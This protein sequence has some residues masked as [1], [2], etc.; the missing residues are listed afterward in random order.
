[1]D[2]KTK[3]MCYDANAAIMHHQRTSKADDLSTLKREL[4]LY[5]KQQEALDG[6]F[7]KELRP[8]EKKILSD[9]YK[10]QIKTR[11]GKIKQIYRTNRALEFEVVDPKRV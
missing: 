2:T 7:A 6:D 5:Y 4:H 3:Q 8:D 10:S 1:M 11:I 9:Y